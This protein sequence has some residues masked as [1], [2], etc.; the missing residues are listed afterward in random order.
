MANPTSA[1]ILSVV[2][3]FTDKVK[4]REL[5]AHACNPSYSGGTDEKDSGLKP[6]RANSLQD[7]S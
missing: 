7:L 6:V 4:K 2:L 1:M 3:R 5:D